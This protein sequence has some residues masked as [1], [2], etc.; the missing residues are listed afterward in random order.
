MEPTVR[1]LL[2]ILHYMH[3]RDCQYSIIFTVLSRVFY[4]LLTYLFTWVENK[5][6]QPTVQEFSTF[7][8]YQLLV[9]VYF[10]IGPS[11][12]GH[13]TVLRHR[14]VVENRDVIAQYTC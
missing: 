4:F 8:S 9:F 11:E 12:R 14:E 1:V 13:Y 7:L 2:L 3:L 5:F 6:L 10:F